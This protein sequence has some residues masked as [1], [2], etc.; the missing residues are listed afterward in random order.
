MPNSHVYYEQ[1]YTRALRQKSTDAAL[2]SVLNGDGGWK[3][4][5]N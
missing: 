5:A 1:V 2:K 4:T 3:T